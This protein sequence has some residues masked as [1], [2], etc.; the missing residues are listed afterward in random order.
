MLSGPLTE[1]DIETFE[2]HLRDT[3]ANILKSHGR[4]SAFYAFLTFGDDVRAA[5]G[6][7][8]QFSTSVT[9]AYHQ[10]VESAQTK[11]SPN[12]VITVGLTRDGL[13]NWDA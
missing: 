13:D 3:Q 4:N 7:L 11:E 9:S 5:A 8:A 6:A 10:Y 1:A 2:P 12:P